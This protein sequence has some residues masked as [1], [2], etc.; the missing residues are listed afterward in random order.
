[1]DLALHVTPIDRYAYV[2]FAFRIKFNLV[3]LLQCRNKMGHMF[4]VYVILAF[5][6][7]F[8]LVR[9]LQCRNKMGRMLLAYVLN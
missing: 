8:N 9:L 5:Y 7:N 6:I 1:M 2:L 3:C 4:L